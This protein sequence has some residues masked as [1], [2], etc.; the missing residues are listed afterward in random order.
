MF[1]K[2]LFYITA[3]LTLCI[4]VIGCS[5]ENPASTNSN[6]EDGE[7]THGGELN[8][9]YHL[10][11]PS[12]DPHLT[13]DVGVRDIAAHIFEPL[14][15]VD[16]SLEPQPM[17]AESFEISDDGGTITFKLRQNITF[18]NGQEM[19][20]SDVI[21]SLERWQGI[22]TQAKS[23]L[24][25]TEFEEADDYTVVATNP[26]STVLDIH[27]LAD[28]TQFAAIMPKDIIDEAG[29]D[30]VSE[31]IGTG[32]YEI[33]ELK[34]DQYVHL[35]RNENYQS[36]TEPADALTGEKNAYMD[37]IY[38]H[39]VADA[40]TRV[41]GL[42][43]GEYDISTNIPHDNTESLESDPNINV[44]I[45]SNS[46]L[47]LVFNKT[48]VFEDKKTRQAINAALDVE[49]LLYAS[50]GNEDYYVK[51][52]ALVTE[53]QTDW[54]TDVGKEEHNTFDQDLAKQLLEESNYNGEEVKIL[55]SAERSNEYAMAVVA[56]EQLAEVGI[57]ATMVESD[58]GTFLERLSDED[59]WDFYF[60][61][62]TFRPV[63]S[64]YLFWNPEWYGW[65]DSPEAEEI[66][67]DILISNP[68]EASQYSEDLHR[69]F[70]DYLPV[71]KV[72]NGSVI[73]ATNENIEGYAHQDGPILWNVSKND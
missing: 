34:Q 46:W 56:Q 49:A 58:W 73:S 44:D 26:K 24:S 40:S 12:I 31:Y 67:D 53:E 36:R 64:Q 65:T 25:E 19:N 38:F 61:S 72:G 60:G 3:L 14:V 41:S 45:S 1:N 2:R 28:L 55:A 9:G 69:V 7:P 57:N 18:H 22:S 48:G 52:H 50:Y 43:S 10:Q 6:N 70:W 62:F 4:M 32:P 54:Y 39:F 15:A 51:D 47:D 21:A 8:V 27:I 63:P 37:D 29:E 16:S 71:I 68:D 30:E 35:T 59:A 20:A 17:L 23:Y 42:Q 13:T 66:N 33:V 11:P 5:S